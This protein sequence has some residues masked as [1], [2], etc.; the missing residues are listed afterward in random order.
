MRQIGT[1]LN[2]EEAKRFADYLLTQGV[3]VKAEQDNGGW[4]IWVRDENHLEQARSELG[5][6]EQNPHDARY[7][8]A[9]RSAAEIRRE[10]KVKTEQIRRNT[11]N[12]GDRWQRPLM[13]RRPLTVVLIALSIFVSVISGLGKDRSITKHLTIAQL[14][15]TNEGTISYVPWREIRQGQLWRLSPRFSFTLVRCTSS[16]TRT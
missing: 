7:Q 15:E 3:E 16:L 5:Q 4:G 6:F 10:E 1:L 9:T 12:M 2:K 11:H 13:Q 8:T 14:T